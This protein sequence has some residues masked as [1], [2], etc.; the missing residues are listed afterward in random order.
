MEGL[1][2]VSV[3]IAE[4]KDASL[5]AEV[6]IASFE[7]DTSSVI[8]PLLYPPTQQGPLRKR[9]ET[10]S[11]AI[12]EGMRVKGHVFVKVM[13]EKEVAGFAEWV[14]PGADE[15]IP[16]GTDVSVGSAEGA[17][18]VTRFKQRVDATRKALLGESRYWCVA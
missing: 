5:L 2:D 13:V 7:A 15:A 11:H 16:S 14:P 12:R 17:A 3:V 6:E 1:S 9:I 4:E 10:R 8:W 18:F